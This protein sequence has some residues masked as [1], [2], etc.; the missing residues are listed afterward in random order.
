[1]KRYLFMTMIFGLLFIIFPLRIEGEQE[2]V[3]IEKELIVEQEETWEEYVYN[4]PLEF[5]NYCEIP[6]SIQELIEKKNDQHIVTATVYN[7]IEGQTDS[8]PY[9]TADNS[10]IDK[11]KLNRG[12]IKWIAVSRDLLSFY[13]YGEVVYIVC[14]DM[15]GYYEIHDI[16]NKRY[17]HRIDFLVPDHINTGKWKNTIITKL[18]DSDGV[19]KAWI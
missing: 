7:A 5:I 2:I 18:T 13:E 15:T 10:R 16:M 8:T 9:I 14:G 12:E 11:E 1:M 3:V 19:R 4:N 17:S 6:D